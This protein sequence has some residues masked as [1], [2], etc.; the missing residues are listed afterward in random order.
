MS[1]TKMKKLFYYSRNR[2]EGRVQDLSSGSGS[3]SKHI[4]LKI[5]ALGIFIIP[6]PWSGNND[7]ILYIWKVIP[8]FETQVRS[9][10]YNTIDKHKTFYQYKDF[11]NKLNS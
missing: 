3:V 8:I 11:L 4:D 6:Q 10:K 5:L 1:D 2:F 7:S 9:C